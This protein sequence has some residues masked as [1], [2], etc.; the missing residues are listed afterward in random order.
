MK[1]AIDLRSLSSGSISGVENYTMHIVESLLKYDKKNQY[2]LFYNSFDG[3]LPGE[4]HYINSRIAQS[5]VPNKILNLAFKMGLSKIENFIVDPRTLTPNPS[6]RGRGENSVDWFFMPNLNQFSLKSNTKLALTVHDMSPVLAPE[7]Y[8]IKRRVWHWFLNYKKAFERANVIFTVSNYTKNDIVRLYNIPE[9]KIKVAYP[10]IDLEEYNPK[11]SLEKMRAL[12][13]EK[14]LPGEFILFLNT[15]EPR[16]NLENLIKSFETLN[17]SASLVIAG[18][19]G[20]KNSNIINLIKKSKKRSKIFYYGYVEPKDKSALIKMSRCLVYPSFYEG[21]GFQ[22]LEAFALGV[23]VLTSQV[24]ALPEVVG[25]AADH[26]HRAT[27]DR[28]LQAQLELP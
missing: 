23:P 17:S 1:I 25:D 28:W 18:G 8:D 11:V 19:S 9:N 24:T 13:N 10:G 26:E 3:K 16:K 7:F 6:P 5:R 21:F 14:G 2:V 4:Y 20:W 22:P 12:R 15:I 27:L